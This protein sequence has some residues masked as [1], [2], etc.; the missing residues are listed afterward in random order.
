MQN[1]GVCD[2]FDFGLNS[3]VLVNYFLKFVGKGFGCERLDLETGWLKEWLV[4]ASVALLKR[5]S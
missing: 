4:S 3:S 5:L 1:V 2:A